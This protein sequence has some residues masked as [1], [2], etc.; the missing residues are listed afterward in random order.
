MLL[1]IIDKNDLKISRADL[2]DL[3]VPMLL[4][5]EYEVDK[6]FEQVLRDPEV[7][8]LESADLKSL[9]ITERQLSYWLKDNIRLLPPSGGRKGRARIYTKADYLTAY[10]ILE[11]D[12]QGISIQQMRGFIPQ[13]HEEFKHYGHTPKISERVDIKV[14]NF[15]LSLEPSY[16]GWYN[17]RF[18]V[19]LTKVGLVEPYER[20]QELYLNYAVQISRKNR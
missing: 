16:I 3:G 5:L 13:M 7:G 2:A 6:A 1:D 15:A 14:N 8:V 17:D 9:G 11:A 4:P 18:W 20:K 10:V 12:R 19:G